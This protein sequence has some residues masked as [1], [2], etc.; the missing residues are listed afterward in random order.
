MPSIA[1]ITSNEDQVYIPTYSV[2]RE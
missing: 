1:E 2:S